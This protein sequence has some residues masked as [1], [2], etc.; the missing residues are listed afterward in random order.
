M[1]VGEKMNVFSVILATCLVG[2]CRCRNSRLPTD[3]F[4]IEILDDY[5]EDEI[6]TSD[7]VEET[8]THKSTAWTGKKLVWDMANGTVYEAEYT[9][10]LARR[11]NDEKVEDVAVDD[12]RVLTHS[13][14]T[15]T[16]DLANPDKDECEFF[17]YP[18]A[19]NVIK[20]IVPK[21]NTT[22][23]RLVDG[24][25][26]IWIPSTGET[27]DHTKVY[28]NKDG[29][30]ELVLV[31]TKRADTSKETYL[32]LKDGKWKS[33]TNHEEKMRILM[34]PAEW[35]S[36]FELDL[37]LAN[38]TDECSSF[39]VDLLGVTTKHFYPKPGHVAIQVKDGNEELWHAGKH[40]SRY[41][42]RI[43][44]MFGGYDD[45]C[46]Y[47]LIYRKGD[48]ELLEIVTVENLSRWWKYFE[49]N[50]DGKWTSMTEKNDFLRKL[51]E[52][53]KSVSP[54]NPSSTT[55]PS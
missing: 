19:G 23:I 37:A 34:A 49:K 24:E 31:V 1:N 43:I 27:F 55:T 26:E 28:L 46:R 9:P 25:K 2:L 17:E 53:R 14:H 13:R 47:C 51:Q 40:V 48:K 18:F 41:G 35:I 7:F 16:L 11:R 22:V 30:P 52:M 38:S 6:V 12:S 32:E 29:T 42:G 4:I 20:L 15:T 8:E 54:P 45:Y 5:A 39:E 50:A 44:G 33:C 36:N 3:R 10:S 21:K